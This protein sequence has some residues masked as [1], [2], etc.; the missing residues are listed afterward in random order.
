MA[1]K[2]ITNEEIIGKAKELW[3]N[4]VSRHEIEK[5]LQ[6]TEVQ[7]NGL[8]SRFKA[9]LLLTKAHVV[10]SV[11]K[12]I[13]D[14]ESKHHIERVTGLSGESVDYLMS[15]VWDLITDDEMELEADA[16]S[17]ISDA[18]KEKET[19]NRMRLALVARLMSEGLGR[20]RIEKQTGYSKAVVARLMNEVKVGNFLTTR[21]MTKQDK[22]STISR[23]LEDDGSIFQIARAMDA[24]P[25]NVRK[26]VNRVQGNHY[27]PDNLLSHQLA[28]GSTLF[29]LINKF[30]LK[31]LEEARGVITE[32]FPNHLVYEKQLPEGDVGFTL[33]QDGS[34]HFEWLNSNK[35]EKQ[36]KYK[37]G[38]KNNYLYI[39]FDPSITKIK[40]FNYTD[41]HV[42]HKHF[43]RER[44][45][46][47]IQMV[48][49]DPNAFVVLGGDII[50]WA[51]K[52]SVG[53]PNEQILSPMEQVSEAARLL[54]PIRHKI[55][56]YR[57][58]NHDKGRGKLTGTDLAEVLAHY[59]EVPYFKVE[60]IIQ[61]SVGGE[62]FTV[63][64][65]HGHSGGA[66]Q[67]ILKDAEKF[68]EYSAFFVHAH[69][70]GHVHNSQI[71]ERIIKDLII[72]EGFVYRR[73]FTIIGGSCVHYTETYAEEAKYSPTPQDL[74]YFEC[75]ADG[76][77]MGGKVRSDGK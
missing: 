15:K 28:K 4:G 70:S 51:H 8:I 32:L 59:L 47:Y 65:D 5:E 34:G 49:D 22:V 44:F 61:M 39:Q 33:I 66:L 31:D 16:I 77:Y 42:G 1:T 62:L 30:G 13:H 52:M 3:L 35:N 76:S 24:P 27:V 73:A 38:E 23:I 21:M 19:Q 64:L 74:T 50:E 45:E 55:L 6:L 25:G 12:A 9:D 18:R 75:G 10:E 26:L 53:D 48:L 36:F 58:G 7:L 71:I 54:M 60:T 14:G 68:R 17:Q 69:F 41:V 37:V 29:Q 57:S 20:I 2:N 46:G 56:A 72:G 67:S 40:L 11:K 43:A 63:S